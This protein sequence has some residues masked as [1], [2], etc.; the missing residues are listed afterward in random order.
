MN[1]NRKC[2]RVSDLL[3]EGEHNEWSRVPR[4]EIHFHK[5]NSGDLVAF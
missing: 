3:C 1:F 4:L 2:L 5:I